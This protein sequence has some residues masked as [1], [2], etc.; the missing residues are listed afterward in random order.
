MD[1]KNTLILRSK[2]IYRW[3]Y[4]QM[5]FLPAQIGVYLKV[6]PT[7][8]GILKKNS[9]T[10][11]IESCWKANFGDIEYITIYNQQVP[12]IQDMEDGDT[13]SSTGLVL[14]SWRELQEN[15]VGFKTQS[16]LPQKKGVPPVPGKD[17]CTYIPQ[18]SK[19]NISFKHVIHKYLWIAWKDGDETVVNN[20]EPPQK[21]SSSI[22]FRQVRLCV[23]DDGM[24]GL[25]E[26][27]CPGSHCWVFPWPWGVPT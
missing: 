14:V 13:P 24:K 10:Q 20:Y 21:E 23:A 16:F 22:L 8:I 17:S 7:K 25:E 9:T 19:P 26:L 15:P 18:I 11:K 1:R 2:T 3:R 12:T 6:Y 4:Q 27:V 5:G